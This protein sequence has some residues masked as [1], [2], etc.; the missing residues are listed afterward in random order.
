[1]TRV[2]LRLSAAQ[3]P[4]D[5][6]IAIKALHLLYNIGMGNQNHM[7]RLTL[8]VLAGWQFYR[9]A[10]N[11]SYL[12]PLFKGISQA[13]KDL[14]FNVLLGCGIGP[15]AR[16]TDPLRPAWPFIS[17]EHDYVPIGPFNTEGLIIAAPLHSGA[18][19]D[20]IQK[21]MAA[22]HP[23]I[24]VGSG[25]NG[26]SIIADN[27]QGILAALKHLKDHGHQ[28]IAF[29]AGSLDD[30]EGDTGDRL[31]AYQ[32]GCHQLGLDE[33]PSLIAYG[34]HVFDGG[35]LAAQEFMQKD[36]DYS[37]ILASND[38]SALGA[39]KALQEAGKRIPQ[40][41]AII[42]FD[43]RLE[44]DVVEP[45]LTSM[46]VPLFSMG[47]RA[48]E[49]LYQHIMLNIP[50][51]SRTF[52]QTRL[53][54]RESCGCKPMEITNSKHSAAYNDQNAVNGKQD[55]Q[56]VKRVSVAVANNAR[57]FTEEKCFSY[58]QNLVEAFMDSLKC[59]EK[60]IFNQKLHEILSDSVSSSD[61]IFIWQVALSI[62]ERWMQDN[63]A[64]DE[65]LSNTGK[66]MISDGRLLI[67]RQMKHQYSLSEV[68][69]RWNASRISLLT[70]KLLTALDENQIFDT[71]A[72][73][74]PEMNIKKAWIALTDQDIREGFLSFE[75]RDL[76]K[77]EEQPLIIRS[78]K[79]PP[80]AMLF[81]KNS[82]QLTLVPLVDPGG[83]LGFMVFDTEH[84]DLYGAIVQ[85]V[86]GALNTAKLYR[87]AIEGR[88]LAEEIN[89]MK[90]R[91][92]SMI[93]HELRTPLNLILGLSHILITESD[94]EK[95]VLP[96]SIQKDIE[97]INAYA[98]HLSGMIGDVID[99]ATNDAGK[100]HLNM[101]LI[102]LSETLQLVVDS[103]SA[104]TFDKGLSWK[105]DL[106]EKGPWVWG[107]Q[108]RLRQVVLNLISNAVKF[109]SH[110]TISLSVDTND[111]VVTVEVCDTGVGI[112]IEEQKAIFNEF[113]RSERS[114][115]LGIPGLGLGLSV[116][117]LLVELHNGK[118]GLRSRG[119]EGEGS[120]FYF[121]LPVVEAPSVLRT[122][123]QHLNKIKQH[124]MILTTQHSKSEQLHNM[125]MERDIDVHVFLMEKVSEWLKHMAKSPPEAIILDVS[126]QSDSGW[127]AL[128]EIKSSHLGRGIPIM[129]YSAMADGEGI[130]DL[131]YL[132]K[133]IELVDLTRAFDTVRLINDTTQPDQTVLVVD[134]E[135]NT[136]D[137]HA[138]I[139]Q[140]QSS[141]YR[142]LK[143][144]DGEQALKIL[145]EEKVDIVLLD[146]QMPKMD[147]FDVLEAMRDSKR[148]RNIPVVVVTG[149]ILTKEDMLR[150]NQG[151]ASVLNK[152]LFSSIEIVNHIDQALQKKRNLSKDAQRLVRQ[153]MAY[154]H[155]HYSEQLTRQEISQKVNIS[156]DYLTYC[157]RQ[158][159]GI[160]P[161]KYLRRYRI[162]QAKLLL[163]AS[164]NSIT[165]IAF[166]VGFSD[167]SYFSR[168]FHRETG[169]S[170]EDFR[171]SN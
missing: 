11:L 164:Q 51:E 29:I 31:S 65:M 12:A 81:S 159:L 42:G 53:V 49:L 104:L 127:S 160:T 80:Q 55:M 131:D 44:G 101:E 14:H 161:I 52:M 167:S 121:S 46:H 15:S 171:Q 94:N 24:F 118:V 156:E 145:N 147:G 26:P 122:V 140:S 168:I 99:L 1:M 50:L 35:Y 90:N 120:C 48:A 36:L 135:A 58:S 70:A 77:R 139:V 89:Q 78:H 40:D 30:L 27:T 10:T 162:K 18:R 107:D 23:V 20:Y 54:I 17:G 138:R 166:A 88:R 158:E 117:K 75:I 63:I 68:D 110:G 148:L 3:N 128:R 64:A 163:K 37:A 109:T 2:W 83:Q 129:F 114:I 152:G 5:K 169:Y 91:F 154:I 57:N 45:G 112:P 143:A 113:Y 87:Q 84:L 125:L 136:L 119:I 100:L 21:L 61:D 96:E 153:A 165:E 19:S 116:C 103:G 170:P 13:A 98:Q 62:L 74:L 47:Y 157:F 85:Q 149:K 155:E 126:I 97:R 92:L 124:V 16:P 102:D 28:R 9:T 150:L 115:T 69:E 73:F 34:R 82:N 33:D 6:L 111:N 134:D 123:S 72:E 60:Q 151:V 41:V 105:A 141:A 22:G 38:E 7:G 66:Q 56:L 130:I 39:M 76:I 4:G 133:P 142:V 71:L 106:P 25:E 146:L 67:S 93:S 132:T 144:Q 43:N 108:I 8:G 86:S 59:G 137:L 32:S 95:V 79:F